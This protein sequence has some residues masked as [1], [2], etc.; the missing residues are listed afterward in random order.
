MADMHVEQVTIEHRHLQQLER[1]FSSEQD[2]RQWAGPEVNVPL[3]A[4]IL[5]QQLDFDNKPAVGLCYG[6]V[7]VAFGQFY[8]LAG[9]CHVCR[10]VVA[11]QHRGKGLLKSL[12]GA[13]SQAGKARLNAQ[14]LSLFVYTENQPAIRAYQ[15]LGFREAGYPL[16]DAIAGCLYMTMPIDSLLS[17]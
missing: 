16:D 1:W 12:M 7:L 10:L 4:A 13:L 15:R 8:E 3:C 6:N 5:N 2:V 9:R 11:P 14:H 17:D